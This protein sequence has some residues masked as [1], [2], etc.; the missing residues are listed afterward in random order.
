MLIRLQVAYDWHAGKVSYGPMAAWDLIE[1]QT[2]VVFVGFGVG[3][4]F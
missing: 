4:G 3:F 1:D 2:N